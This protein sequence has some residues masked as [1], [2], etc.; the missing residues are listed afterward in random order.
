MMIKDSIQIDVPSFCA[1]YYKQLRISSLL[2]FA[3]LTTMLHFDGDL[4]QKKIIQHCVCSHIP[5][6]EFYI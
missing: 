3:L 2:D 5:L 4:I 6:Y 1:L